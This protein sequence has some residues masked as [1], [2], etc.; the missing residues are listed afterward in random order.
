MQKPQPFFFFFFPENPIDKS[1]GPYTQHWKNNFV[2]F[3]GLQILN[4]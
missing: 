2:G 4:P 1:N 3:M